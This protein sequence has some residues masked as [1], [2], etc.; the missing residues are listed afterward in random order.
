VNENILESVAAAGFAKALYY[1]G[2]TEVVQPETHPL[3]KREYNTLFFFLSLSLSFL[4]K[5]CAVVC[6]CWAHPNRPSARPRG[7]TIGEGLRGGYDIIK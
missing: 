3:S 7:K 2:K 1:F 5:C 6:V 4:H